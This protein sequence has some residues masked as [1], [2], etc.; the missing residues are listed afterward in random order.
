MTTITTTTAAVR[1]IG[2]FGIP[3][4]GKSFAMEQL[5]H[6]L[7]ESSFEYFEG[8][9]VID[10][11]TPSGLEG[12]QRLD[13]NEKN[14]VRKFAVATI[15]SKCAQTRKVGIGTGHFMFWDQEEDE[16]ALR[17]C[18]QA[19]LNTYTHILYINTPAE[20]TVKQRADDSER[21]RSNLSIKHLR[22]WQEAEINELHLLC[23]ENNIHFAMVYPNLIDKLASTI[24]DFQ[25]HDEN[26]NTMVA[27]Q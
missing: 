9:K 2:L 4:C 21:G 10:S 27:E 13:D 18:T 26:H 7:G 12:F 11:V 23:R 22:C 20:E 19:G 17:V 14:Q 5:K 25:L 3:G 24:H 8:S 6:E 1:V 15:K 16:R